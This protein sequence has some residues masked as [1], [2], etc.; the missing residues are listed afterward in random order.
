MRSK[1]TVVTTDSA[2]P[3]RWPNRCVACGTKEHLRAASLR[4][5]RTQAANVNV[6]GGVNFENL[7]LHLDYPVCEKHIRG[8]RLG[9]WLVEK[10]LLPRLLR[11]IA[12]V[13]GP[14]ALLGLVLKLLVLGVDAGA[15]LGWWG[16]KTSS[17]G[18]RPDSPLIMQAISV[19]A[20]AWLVLVLVATSRLPV[21]VLE[22]ADDAVT[23]SFRNR[24]YAREFSKAN[25]AIIP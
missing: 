22:L 15:A 3:I 7:V 20:G 5:G 18:M 13:V 21:R 6:A 19:L 25:D 1:V 8:L 23:L 24:K 10:S 2:H 4:A 17:P 9:H 16:Q 11:L 14:L 12:Y